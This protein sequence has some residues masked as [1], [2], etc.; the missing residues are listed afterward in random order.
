MK[1]KNFSFYTLLLLIF[2]L[3]LSCE[4]QNQTTASATGNASTDST[5]IQKIK[6]I[7]TK[8]EELMLASDFDALL[9]YFTKDVLVLPPLS[10]E[11]RG[12][13]ALRKHYMD[14]KQQGAK[15]RS[16]SGKAEK[17]WMDKN[18]VYEYGTYGA[19]GT[20]KD[21]PKPIAQ[22]GNYFMMWEKQNDGSYLIKY[23]IENLDFN[24]CD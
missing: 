2:L 16:F 5:Y 9:K 24:P 6:E 12:I 19:S 1:L 7:N 17:M 18:I 11:I 14:Q 8:I 3:F 22:S 13:D 21:H 4:K 10:S 20:I 15:I 23:I